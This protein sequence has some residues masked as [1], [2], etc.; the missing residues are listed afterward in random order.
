M[1]PS[2]SVGFSSFSLESSRGKGAHWP[3]QVPFRVAPGLATRASGLRQRSKEATGRR[4]KKKAERGWGN[5]RSGKTFAAPS[6]LNDNKPPT[7]AP[8]A[9]AMGS[10][11][12]AAPRTRRTRDNSLDRVIPR[13]QKGVAY[14][15]P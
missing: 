1:Y 4:N 7:T 14:Y 6:A 9:E 10:W 2:A 13:E 12:S 5:R 3:A 8:E 15:T 11:G